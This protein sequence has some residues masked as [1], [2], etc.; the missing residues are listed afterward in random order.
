MELVK[1]LEYVYKLLVNHN[2]PAEK[3]K[4]LSSLIIQQKDMKK[5]CPVGFIQKV[6]AYPLYVFYWSKYGLA[7]Y[8]E[9]APNN[10]LFWDATDSICHRSEEGKHML[11]YELAIRHPVKSKMGIPVTLMITSDQSLP[12]IC[13]W[14]KS[15]RHAE[16]KMSCFT[17]EM[18]PKLIIIDQAMVF[19][20]AALHECNGEN[21][22]MF[23]DR[24][25][26]TVNRGSSVYDSAKILVHLC[27]SHFMNTC[28]KYIEKKIEKKNKNKFLYMIGLLMNCTTLS[29]AEQ[30][31]AGIF[32]I[33]MSPCINDHS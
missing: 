22:G 23:L 13:D 27:A 11:Y 30:L 3:T 29:D 15:F 8:H 26:A 5:N 1:I 16:K 24:A 19:I 14:I 17:K 21:M 33:F 28:K 31:L 32:V 7:V 6:C 18:T 4:T 2:K 9:R 25:L 10:V 12:V 20:L